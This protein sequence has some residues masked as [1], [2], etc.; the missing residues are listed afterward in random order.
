M[1]TLLLQNRRKPH[2][3]VFEL[4]SLNKRITIRAVHFKMKLLW[5]AVGCLTI[6]TQAAKLIDLTSQP[7][8]LSAPILPSFVSFSIEFAFFPDFAG[9]D[10]KHSAETLLIVTKET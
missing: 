7:T 1:D 10:T 6:L 9:N 3:E 4:E 2:H 5:I 8:N